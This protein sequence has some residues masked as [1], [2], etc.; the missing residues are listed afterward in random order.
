MRLCTWFDPPQSRSHDPENVGLVW[1]LEDIRGP[2][3]DNSGMKMSKD[4]CPTAGSLEQQEIASVPVR[5]MIGSLR[6]VERMTRPYISFALKEV[7]KV[8]G[9]S[10]TI[11][12]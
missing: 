2:N 1:E 11:P 7:V 5:P 6:H 9:E 10:R 12:C 4:Q 8:Y 3:I